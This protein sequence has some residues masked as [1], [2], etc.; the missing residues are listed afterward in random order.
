MDD[1]TRERESENTLYTGFFFLPGGKPCGRISYKKLVVAMVMG[2]VAGSSSVC[3]AAS[4]AYINK[5]GG[6]ISYLTGYGHTVT[7]FYNPS[8]LQLSQLQGLTWLL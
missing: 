1:R 4:I 8:G 5:S 6:S 7:D 2:V 3:F